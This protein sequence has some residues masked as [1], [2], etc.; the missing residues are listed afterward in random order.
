MVEYSRTA[1]WK[2]YAHC[3]S[4]RDRGRAM[5]FPEQPQPEMTIGDVGFINQET[6]AFQR[7]WNV[8][9]SPEDKLNEFVG[10]PRDYQTLKYNAILESRI[11]G[12]LQKGPH[13][14]RNVK[15]TNTKAG[16]ESDAI[17][18]EIGYI[19]SCSD[20]QG[21]VL[22][23]DDAAD[24]AVVYKNEVWIRYIRENYPSWIE[25]L[26]SVGL[27]DVQLVV[28]RGWIKTSGWAAAVWRD[29]NADGPEITLSGNG[30]ISQGGVAFRIS[31]VSDSSPLHRIGPLSEQKSHNSNS[32]ATSQA[33]RDQCI[34]M[35]YF[36]VTDRFLWP[37]IKAKAGYHDLPPSDG[38]SGDDASVQGDEPHDPLDDVIDYIFSVTEARYAIVSDADVYELCEGSQIL[39][40][41]PAY[42]R[43]RAPRCDL[44]DDD[45]A[46]IS[47][48]DAI[49]K[50]YE[51]RE[52]E[53]GHTTVES[54]QD[55]HEERQEPREGI[56][57][58]SH[59]ELGTISLARDNGVRIEWP[60]IVLLDPDAEKTAPCPAALSENGSLVAVGSEDT[61]VNVWNVKTEKLVHRLQG[62]DDTVLCTAFSPDG[63]TLASGSADCTLMLWDM[64]SGRGRMR[65]E[66]HEGDV[67]SAAFSPDGSGLATGSVDTTVRF[68]SV[69]TG[70]TYAIGEGHSAVVQNLLFTPDGSLVVSCAD[71]VGR[72]WDPRS[73]TG[74]SV[75]MGHTGAIWALCCSHSGSKVAT[76]SED[77]T[78]RIW[79]PDTGDELVTIRDHTGP[80]WS[81]Q[82]S[83]DDRKIISGSSDSSI[84]IHDALTGDLCF[85]LRAEDCAVHSIAWSLVGN[86]VA[87]GYVDGSL[88]LWDATNGA[89]IAELRGH[90][91][92][93][94]SIM[95]SP[96]EDGIIT[97]S[98]DG[99][100]RIWSAIDVMKVC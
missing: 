24:R 59:F 95:F 8:T 68:W 41:F 50:S 42:L 46:Y 18:S 86:L 58:G 82:F 92:K 10:L 70:Q 97:S 65:L 52:A 69:A 51:N 25:I 7:L 57:G 3:L 73:G 77:H 71:M 33:A 23:I 90:T 88:K 9:G 11:K 60:H 47:I 38:G 81:V 61:V 74:L 35:P 31:D 44:I 78:T 1:A 12:Y 55:P 75:M 15:C 29:G 87:G 2:V 83:P 99:T 62:H 30:R 36:K 34:Y 85:A 5:W 100:V 27:R 21:A 64:D 39:P 14:S 79:S 66:G 43:A 80:V 13:G 67:W 22:Y 37:A 53:P 17:E 40:D 54:V 76:G 56:P 89:K 45:V 72:V 16:H 4:G 19:F 6:G 94:K 48:F 63:K 49:Y 96:D 98:D 91:D 93:I 26:E 28:A 20:S 84:T 32:T